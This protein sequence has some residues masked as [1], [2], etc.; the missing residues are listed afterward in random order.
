MVMIG[1]NTMGS[2][3]FGGGGG[4]EAN[5]MDYLEITVFRGNF[6]DICLHLV[7]PLYYHGIIY[8]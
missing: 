1:Y 3:L 5:F 6:G 2:F 4:V 7:N 8:I